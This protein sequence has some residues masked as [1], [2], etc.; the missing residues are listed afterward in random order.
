ML[1]C[2]KI[3]PVQDKQRLTAALERARGS[4]LTYAP[5]LDLFG[6]ELRRAQAVPP[7]QVP[8]DMVTMNSRIAIRD[9]GTGEAICYTL[10]YPEQ[11][12]PH[13]GLI[14]ALSPMG[15]ALLGARV[16]EEVCWLC[17]DGPKA[18][19]VERLIY[20]PESAGDHHL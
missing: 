18:A 7:D 15:M 14:S 3:V 8:R 16:G 10:V 11:E 17:T 20:Q 1:L 9:A 12:A 4:W 2:K 19:A 6:S 13:A 5:Y